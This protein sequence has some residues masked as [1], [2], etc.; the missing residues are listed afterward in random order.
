MKIKGIIILSLLIILFASIIA[1][2]TNVLLAPYFDDTYFELSDDALILKVIPHEK[3]G[4]E[5]DVSAYDGLLKISGGSTSVVKVKLNATQ[6]PTVNND[7]DEGYAVGSRW[8]DVTNDKEYVCLDNTDGAAVWIE[9]TQSGGAGTYL[10]LTDTPAAY[11]NGKYA[12]STADG[13]VWDDPAGAGENNTASNI[14]SQIEIYKQKTEV[15]LEFR[16]LKAGSS[17]IVLTTTSTATKKIYCDTI[18]SATLTSSDANRWFGQ[19][20]TT[21]DS[22]TMGKISIWMYRTNSPGDVI[23]HFYAADGN[24]EPTGEEL[25]NATTNCNS[26]VTSGGEWVDF[27]VTDYSLDATTKYVFYMSCANGSETNKV[28]W[29]NAG[30]DVTANAG[31]LYTMNG[32][33]SW[34]DFTEDSPFQVWSSVITLDYIEFDVDESEIRLD[35]LKATE[36]NADLDASTTA[37]GLMPKLPFSGDLLSTTTVAFNADADTTLYTVPTGKRCVLSHAII[38]AAGDAGATTTV[39]IGANGSETDFIPANILSNLDAEYDA[40]ILMPIPNTTPLKIK[41]Y[42]AA[43]IIEAQVASQSGMTGNTIYLFGIL[44]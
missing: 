20:F 36:D 28:H 23:L 27:N 42:A 6:A 29:F 7:V 1:F 8:C 18:G 15:D 41:S 11:D 22:F 21:T 3:G 2:G 12:K 16:T 24:N 31:Y 40:V 17:K 44:Y 10:E 37:H 43:T 32:G 35:N 38:V 25:T 9:A 39:S 30:S 34:T 19:Y 26:I 4:L 33:G 13:V 5:A 14:G